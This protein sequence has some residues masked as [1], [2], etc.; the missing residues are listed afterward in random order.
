MDIALF[1]HLTY[2][3]TQKPI[4]DLVKNLRFFLQK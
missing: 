3:I 1:V 2:S 4:Y